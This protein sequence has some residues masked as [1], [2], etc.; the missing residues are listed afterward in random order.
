MKAVLDL[1]EGITEDAGVDLPVCVAPGTERT[2]M[3]RAKMHVLEVAGVRYVDWLTK[4]IAGE[5]IGD[6]VCTDC[7]APS[8]SP[9]RRHRRLSPVRTAVLEITTM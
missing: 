2:I 3:G 5:A 8:S 1:N 9:Q 6:V 7:G 4:F